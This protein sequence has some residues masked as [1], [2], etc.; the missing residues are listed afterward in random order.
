M[1]EP[2]IPWRLVASI[3]IAIAL[4]AAGAFFQR[5]SSHELFTGLVDPMTKKGCCNDADC[6]IV[7]REW[8]DAG[9]ILPWIGGTYRVRL[10]LEQARFFNPNMREPV[11]AI[12]DGA[13]VIWA[14][15]AQWAICLN[16]SDEAAMPPY[17]GMRV[18]CLIGFSGS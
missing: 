3:I 16:P 12:V 8:I 18:R 15:P 1:N 10:T 14:I 4:L 2:V 7:P 17:S 5:A 13:R 6:K 11:D 9:V